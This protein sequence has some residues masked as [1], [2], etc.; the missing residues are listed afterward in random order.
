MGNG[1]NATGEQALFIGYTLF[2]NVH[3]YSVC[4][5]VRLVHHHPAQRQNPQSIKRDDRAAT[6]DHVAPEEYN[7]REKYLRRHFYFIT[8]WACFL[9]RKR[10]VKVTG[11]L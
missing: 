5:N 1:K 4:E 2:P 10:R 9:A 3:A 7:V 8:L 6:Q 11:H